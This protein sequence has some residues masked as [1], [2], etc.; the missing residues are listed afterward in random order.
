MANGKCKEEDFFIKSVRFHTFAL[1]L[2]TFYIIH[3]MSMK[4]G[5][6]NGK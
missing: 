6:L 4:C 2:F 1:Y 5:G 3:T